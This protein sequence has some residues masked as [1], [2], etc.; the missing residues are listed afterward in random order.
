MVRGKFSGKVSIMDAEAQMD[1]TMLINQAEKEYQDVM[2]ELTKRLERM[3]PWEIM[4]KSA[5]LVDNTSKVLAAKP[6]KIM[7]I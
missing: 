1:Y 6:L 7:A 2:D 3:S 5:E 4:K